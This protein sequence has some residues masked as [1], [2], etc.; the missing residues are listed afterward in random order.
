MSDIKQCPFCGKVPERGV[1]ARGMD[2]APKGGGAEMRTDPEWVDPP[3]I[4]LFF[5]DGQIAIG[6]WDWYYADG[7]RGY[8]GEPAWICQT[9]GA[10]L[11]DFYGEPRGWLP[12]SWLSGGSK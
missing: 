5:D 10:R 8:D 3:K 2:S 9:S 7:G 11:H 4:V 12:I 6:Y 1:E